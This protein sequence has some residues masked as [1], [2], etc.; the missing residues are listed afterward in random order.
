MAKRLNGTATW[1]TCILAIAIVG[2]NTIAV[3]VIAKNDVKHLQTTV[4]ELKKLVIEHI[5]F[6]ATKEL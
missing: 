1:I 6:H 3:H 4:V 2:Y 5:V